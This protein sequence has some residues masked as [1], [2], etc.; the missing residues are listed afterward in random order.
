P[1]FDRNRVQLH[2]LL[3]H[4][5][6]RIDRSA[7]LAFDAGAWRFSRFLH[8]LDIFTGL[9]RNILF[10]E[11]GE[12]ILQLRFQSR[13]LLLCIEPERPQLFRFHVDADTCFFHIHPPHINIFMA[14]SAL[15]QSAIAWSYW[16]N[17]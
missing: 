8:A 9:S 1:E 13:F 2:H 12:K 15:A 7:G 10:V 17:N 11:L 6:G 3:A 16:T 14:L 5:S 4:R